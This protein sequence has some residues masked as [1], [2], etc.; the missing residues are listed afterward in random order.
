MENTVAT[1]VDSASKRVDNAALEWFMECEDW[2]HISDD[3]L[4]ADDDASQDDAKYKKLALLDK[5]IS[6]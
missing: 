5:R 1:N 6:V 2:D 3:Q 4:I